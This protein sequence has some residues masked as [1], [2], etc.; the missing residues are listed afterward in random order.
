MNPLYAMGL[1][2]LAIL[3]L[4]SLVMIFEGKNEYIK[5]DDLFIFGFLFLLLFLFTFGHPY[6]GG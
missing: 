4:T 6:F 1:I 2:I 5:K 3:T